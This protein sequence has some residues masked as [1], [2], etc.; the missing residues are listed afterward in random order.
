MD[1]EYAIKILNAKENIEVLYNGTPVWIESVNDNNTA[2]V[3]Y[4]ESRRVED[5]PVY[6]LVESS[7][8]NIR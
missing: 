1:S 2:K 8:D 6:K 7:K 3:T 4:L 5:V